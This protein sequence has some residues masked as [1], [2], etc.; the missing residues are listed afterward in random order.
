MKNLTAS[1]RAVALM[2]E[3]LD[4]M[5]RVGEA[6]DSPVHSFLTA[7]KRRQL[8]R[9]AKRLRQQKTEPRYKNLHSAEELAD[10][11]ERTARRDEI[12]EQGQKDLHRITAELRRI[13][14]EKDAEVEKAVKTLLYESARSAIEHGPGSEA[15]RRHRLLHYWWWFGGQVLAH[16][17][18]S[19]V[20]Y[21]EL[22][23]P[24]RDLS[25]QPRMELTAAEILD[26][27]PPGEAV[28]AIPPEGSGSGRDR[29]YVRI[30]LGNASWIGSFELGHTKIG[31]IS[32][33]PDNKHLFVSAK[34]AGYIIDLKTR[35]LVEQIGTHVAFVWRDAPNT[36]LTVDH[37][38][39]SLEMFGRSGRL[40]KT[41]TISAGGFRE[42]SL[43]DGFIA[44]EARR[45]SGEGW[46]RF[47]VK[48]ATG[49][50]RFED[51]V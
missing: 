35:T 40:W 21:S 42:M 36:L 4:V 7:E 10:L 32:M 19:L 3:A 31:S 47:S 34:G 15:D 29:A 13:R 38:G 27:P 12:R 24:T 45:G 23:P 39:M 37:N 30:G 41:D 44:G 48:V 16:R 50:V 14:G 49:E 9:D 51:G 26:S 25:A 28:I 11:Y 1:Q 8:R 46:V 33:M 18:K 6:P 17:R 43:E 2:H 20:P 22:F 5:V